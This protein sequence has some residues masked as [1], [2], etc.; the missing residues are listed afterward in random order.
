MW[1][2]LVAVA[3]LA[4]LGS[5]CGTAR[6]T[7][8][9]PYPR[10]AE[11]RLN[12]LQAVGTQ[13]SYH[14]RPP[15]QSVVP[16]W[17]YAHRPLDQQLDMGVRQL[18]LDIHFGADGRFRVFNVP[19]GDDNTTC[20]LLHD[21]LRAV[22]DWSAGH[23]LHHPLVILIQPEDTYDAIKIDGRYD[24]LDRE[25]AAVVPRERLITP[26]D[27][28]GRHGTLTS[29]V[30]ADGWPTLSRSRGHLLFVLAD[31]GR[32]RAAY[33]RGGASLGGRAM[34][35]FGQDGPIDAIRNVPDPIRGEGEIRR[36]VREGYLVR[37]EADQ[38]GIEA[39]IGDTTRVQAALR[40]GA[41]LISTNYPTP[42]DITNY[43]VAIPTGEP[44]R[45]NPIAAHAGCTPLDIENPRFLTR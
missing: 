40:S 14:L 19:A 45:C 20:E 18:E 44:S 34:F 2:V 38:D 10:D 28:R 8:P 21:C 36:L 22:R 4:L 17:D 37:T 43:L 39:R 30:R 31:E 7:A 42:A 15:G 32:H 13:N 35:V 29:A 11:L 1:R 23:P 41:Q 16:Q 27:V 33:S 6:T 12:Q 25:I 3:S 24:A 5:A 26:D 9:L